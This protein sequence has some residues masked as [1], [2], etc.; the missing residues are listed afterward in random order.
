MYDPISMRVSLRPVYSKLMDYEDLTYIL[1]LSEGSK[2]MDFEMATNGFAITCFVGQFSSAEIH[3]QH[4]IIYIY[5]YEGLCN[6]CS[7]YM[8]RDYIYEVKRF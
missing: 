4:H 5:I 3:D 7:K 2:L 6:S 1:Y 8:D